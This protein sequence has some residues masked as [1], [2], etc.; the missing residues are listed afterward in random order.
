M[1]KILMVI[2]LAL[3]TTSKLLSELVP[4]S[5][6]SCFSSDEHQLRGLGGSVICNVLSRQLI[7]YVMMTADCCYIDG[8]MVPG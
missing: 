5:F 7:G 8:L 4:L 2:C 3:C 1:V 6:I